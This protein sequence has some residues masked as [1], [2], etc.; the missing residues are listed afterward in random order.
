MTVRKS[1]GVGLV[2]ACLT[3][4]VMAADAHEDAAQAAADSWLKLVD[5][6]DYAGSWDHV[7]KVLKGAVTQAAWVQMT[8]GARAP[9]GTLVSRKVT[10]RQY[11]EKPPTT[12]VVGGKVYTW[13]QGKY[14]VLRYSTAFANRPS[15][16]ETVTMVTDTDGTWR[17]AGY[18]V[19]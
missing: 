19:P 5:A 18:S 15:A 8:T 13:G 4:L 17:V 3:G 11:T 10:S 9:L 12:R 14:V 7:A 2:L 16:V 1:V 6:G